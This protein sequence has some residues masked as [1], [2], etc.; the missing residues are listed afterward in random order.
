TCRPPQRGMQRAAMPC[1]SPAG[2]GQPRDDSAR[3]PALRFWVPEEQLTVRDDFAG[4]R[5]FDVA[6]Q[7]G[8]FVI[9]K[10]DGTPSY[11]LAVAVDDAE[12]GITRVV[13]G[14][15]LLDSTPR[16]MLL[17]RALGWSDRL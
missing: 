14:N 6:R 12:M 13:R 16:Q 9:R 1:P 17:Y 10:N 3:A 5:S 11:Q 4:E 8:E 7:L 2:A 15:D